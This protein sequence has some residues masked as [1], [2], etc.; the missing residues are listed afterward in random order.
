MDLRLIAILIIV[1]IPS[2]AQGLPFN[3]LPINVRAL[4]EIFAKIIEYR[5][6]LLKW[7]QDNSLYIVIAFSSIPMLVFMYY[8]AKLIFRT[9]RDITILIVRRKQ[10]LPIEKRWYM[11]RIGMKVIGIAI[12]SALIILNAGVLAWM[13]QFKNLKEMFAALEKMRREENPL[14]IIQTLL[15]SL[16]RR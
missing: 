2:L 12:L 5:D 7:V 4:N 6:M 15:E 16:R 13:G 1:A 10:L 11:W 3:K 9:F 8:D 14:K